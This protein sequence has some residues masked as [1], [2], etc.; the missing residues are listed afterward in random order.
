MTAKVSVILPFHREPDSL[1]ESAI[2]SVKD[3]I[4]LNTELIL[5]DDRIN[6][7]TKFLGFKEACNVTSGGVGYA[8]ALNLGKSFV[9]SDYLALMNSDDLIH[10]RRL[11]T[12][13]RLIQSTGIAISLC[14]TKNIGSIF[15]HRNVLGSA[16][17]TFYS[18]KL[19]LLG[20][21][22]AN[23]SLVG[24]TKFF[25]NRYWD[26]I[27]MSDWKFALEN[28]PE[29]IS[30]S[31]TSELLYFYRRH[32]G[33]VT[34]KERKMH[35]ALIDC[36]RKYSESLGLVAGSDAVIKAAS[37]P[38]LFPNLSPTDKID[39]INYLEKL[40]RYFSAEL[41][42]YELAEVEKIIIR[43]LLLADKGRLLAPYFQ[44]DSRILSLF[45]IYAEIPRLISDLMARALF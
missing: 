22:G 30:Q 7:V 20:A 2:T 5:V 32:S 39:L 25:E 11:I 38:Y 12:Q 41:K 29:E 27:D 21:Y 19:L 10:P 8:S 34:K 9:Q 40:H 4:G 35:S 36:A 42:S 17:S 13:V 6:P 1:L 44:T 31:S 37:A 33:Q 43:R 26:D 3:S 24:L 18:K 23:A 28:Y 45:K 16:P 15:A 14:G